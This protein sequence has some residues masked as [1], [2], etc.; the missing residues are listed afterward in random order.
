MAYSGK[1]IRIMYNEAII[2]T[3]EY[4]VV[5]IRVDKKARIG[6]KVHFLVEDIVVESSNSPI[7]LSKYEVDLQ[8]EI[9]KEFQNNEKINDVKKKK[10]KKIFSIVAVVIVFMLI[11]VLFQIFVGFNGREYMYV[12]VDINP[13]FSFSVN[14]KGIVNNMN[15][16]NEDA[17]QNIQGLELE[18]VYFLDVLKLI[19]DNYKNQQS[20][21]EEETLIFIA[22]S[23]NNKNNYE[24]KEKNLFNELMSLNNALEKNKTEN[25]KIKVIIVDK[26]IRDEA[27]EHKVS[28]GKYVIYQQS[29]GGLEISLEVI[30]EKD[31]CELLEFIDI[32]DSDGV[33]DLINIHTGYVYLE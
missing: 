12:D 7:C 4:E 21:Y 6:E 18:K 25:T 30:R 9:N 23:F 31:I 29:K 20:I 17:V 10:S 13:S 22:V 5:R 26:K 16:L 24:L 27:L 15:L 3:N 19:L 14:K 2:M 1:I 28:M 33:K 8:T 11:F 32:V